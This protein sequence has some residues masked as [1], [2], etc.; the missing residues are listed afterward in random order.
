[1]TKKDRDIKNE[2]MLWKMYEDVSNIVDHGVG[3]E[4]DGGEG[5][6]VITIKILK[7]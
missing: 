5:A 6:S 1:M 2:K 4:G 3:D 7:N